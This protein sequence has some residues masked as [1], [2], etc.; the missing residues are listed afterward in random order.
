MITPRVHAERGPVIAADSAANA[1]ARS[2]LAAISELRKN[3]RRELLALFRSKQD[4]VGP[5][6]NLLET[7]LDLPAGTLERFDED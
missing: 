3:N 7:D 4:V 6:A 2:V 5:R 1:F